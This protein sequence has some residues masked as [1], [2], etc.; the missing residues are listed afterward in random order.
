M[1][2]EEPFEEQVQVL[3]EEAAYYR[4]STDE[5]RIQ[6]AKQRVQNSALPLWKRQRAL[7]YLYIAY[8]SHHYP[9]VD[10][11]FP[12][13]E[14]LRQQYPG[15]EPY[16]VRGRLRSRRVVE[17]L[18]YLQGLSEPLLQAFGLRV[19]DRHGDCMARRPQRRWS[20]G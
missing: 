20:V 5:Q 2:I 9:S 15:E 7:L 4:L 12:P 19:A 6:W 8:D 14:V 16:V 17:Y 1:R 18:T 13:D 3:D 11:R 10:D